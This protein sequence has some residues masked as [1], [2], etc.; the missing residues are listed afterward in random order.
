MLRK[1][2]IAE[3]LLKPIIAAAKLPKWVMP[4]KA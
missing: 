2:K 4:E 1:K 3:N